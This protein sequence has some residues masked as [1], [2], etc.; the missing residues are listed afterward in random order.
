MEIYIARQPI[1]KRNKKL[2]GYELLFRGGMSNAFPDIDGDTAPSKLL[3]NNFFSIGINQLTG[4][5]R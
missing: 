3:S 4:G 2:Y 5:R 1:F